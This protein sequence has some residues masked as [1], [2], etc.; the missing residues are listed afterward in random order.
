MSENYCIFASEKGNVLM[1][2][3]SASLKNENNQ[4]PMNM[5]VIVIYHQPQECG[6]PYLTFISQ[7]TG[8]VVETVDVPYG[9]YDSGRK[10]TDIYTPVYSFIE[11]VRQSS[12][13][14]VGNL[15]LTCRF[16]RNPKNYTFRVTKVDNIQEHTNVF[17]T[18]TAD[19][20]VEACI[21]TTKENYSSR[22]DH[23]RKKLQ[24]SGFDMSHWTLSNRYKTPFKEFLTSI[25]SNYKDYHLINLIEIG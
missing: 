16:Y 21:H 25:C 10:I 9:Y 4:R 12:V 7:E 11:K 1:F 3:S 24:K 13:P 23:F 19:V 15:S 6:S 2:K 22:R 18:W 14:T 17:T 8:E 20:H 5:N